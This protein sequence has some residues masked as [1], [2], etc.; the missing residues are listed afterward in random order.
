M[1]AGL[2]LAASVALGI[3]LGMLAAVRVGTPSDNL[4]R[5]LTLL[6]ASRPRII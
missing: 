5:L 2:A 3:P 6:S 4:V 1:L